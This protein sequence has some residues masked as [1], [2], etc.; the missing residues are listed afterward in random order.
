MKIAERILIVLAI[1]GLIMRFF[2]IPG[3]AVLTIFPLAI[4]GWIYL[5]FGFILFNNIKFRKIF[6]KESY[7]GISGLRLAYAI[8]TGLALSV[9]VIGIVFKMMFWPGS[10]INLLFGIVTVGTALTV[11]AIKFIANK[12][13]FYRNMLFRLTP[14]LVVGL[15]LFSIKFEDLVRLMYSD[16]P[17]Y[18]EAFIERE[19]DPM[20]E[21][22]ANKAE[23]E[24][25]RMY[26]S[27]EEFKQY[28]PEEK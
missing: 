15:I 6:K 21:E 25:D 23:L 10:Y 7:N 20:N 19:N 12:Q 27:P 5:I 16:Y 4:L 24:R 13:I 18:A 14:Y 3:G 11:A 8:L 9:I 1:A 17:A 22:K 28:H 26:M 2:H